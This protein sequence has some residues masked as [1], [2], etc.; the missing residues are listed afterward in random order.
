MLKVFNCSLNAKTV[1]KVPSKLM[2][3]L[4]LLK[5]MKQKVSF[6]R[7]EKRCSMCDKKES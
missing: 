1:H 6:E 4:T 5:S 3:K 2:L 7:K